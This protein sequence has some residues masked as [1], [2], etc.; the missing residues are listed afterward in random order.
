MTALPAG[1]TQED[2]DRY[3]KLDAGIKALSIEHKM[4]ND[5]IKKAFLTKGVFVCGSV[6]IERS[7]SVGL[8]VKAVE[9]AYPF[10]TNPEFYS[11]SLDRTKV[12]DAVKGEFFTLT[13]KLS[14]KIITPAVVEK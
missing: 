6:V 5:K 3:A 9:A 7:S 13:E 2:L 11:P 14:V 10:E 8:D 4:I 12:S 1:I